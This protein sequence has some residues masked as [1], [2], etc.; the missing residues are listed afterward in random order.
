ML[1]SRSD[2][3]D[4]KIAKLN[5]IYTFN[6]HEKNELFKLCLAS[7]QTD[8]ID[9]WSEVW[10]SFAKTNMAALSARCVLNQRKK[11]NDQ[12]AH[13]ENAEIE[14]I[15][16]VKK[17]LTIA[18]RYFK[19]SK[20]K[21]IKERVKSLNLAAL[22]YFTHYNT[23][24]TT[25]Y[26]IEDFK[27]ELSDQDS[28]KGIK[29]WDNPLYFSRLLALSK[30]MDYTSTLVYEM[31]NKPAALAQPIFKQMA[32]IMTQKNRLDR[33]A[34]AVVDSNGDEVVLIEFETAKSVLLS[35]I[36]LLS[37]VTAYY[38]VTWLLCQVHKQFLMNDK[39]PRRIVLKGM[40]YEQLGEL[41]GAGTSS[42]AIDKIRKII[43]A[44]AGCLFKYRT[45]DRVGEGNF[46]SYRYERAINGKYSILVIELQPIACPG[47][48]KTLPKGGLLFQEQR[49][50]VPV[51]RPFPVYGKL[52][53]YYGPQ[54]RFQ[55]E[56]Q[57][58]MRNR[59]KELYTRGG[60]SLSDEAL[61]D[62]AARSHL[63]QSL[64]KPVLEFWVEEKCL[65]KSDDGLYN[66]GNRESAARRMIEEAGKYEIEGAVAAKKSLEKQR[67]KIS[68]E[69][70]I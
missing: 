59:A 65:F 34:K 66:I 55:M 7:K 50:V 64:I 22:T 25:K 10:D 14:L 26:L 33:E 36:P 61:Y 49:K 4:Q 67:R 1:L 11:K 21:P 5:K 38:V 35:A 23:G 45:Q 6:E 51:M 17:S 12:Y 8:H 43:P 62:F 69:S 48:I 24:G 37:S 44:L 57:M 47:F 20:N 18:D 40:A 19:T 30:W 39:H 2:F 60:I 28:K 56:L 46:L 15:N 3:F 58:E 29:N 13:Y 31:E 27:K 16:E 32:N 53:N 9:A 63:S 70:K 42:D 68:G 54:L 52:R 41:S